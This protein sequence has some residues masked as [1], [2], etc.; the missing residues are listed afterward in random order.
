LKG[1]LEGVGGGGGGGGVSDEKN[2][3]DRGLGHRNRNYGRKADNRGL[4]TVEK[5]RRR[6][7]KTTVVPAWDPFLK[8]WG[9][10]RRKP[11][12][13]GSEEAHGG[14]RK[15][16]IDA[17]PK[18]ETGFSPHPLQEGERHQCWGKKF[19][20]MRGGWACEDREKTGEG[21]KL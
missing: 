17:L 15:Q 12:E 13:N 7:K 11:R 6:K 20:V 19:V 18:R 21:P 14:G 10:L 2:C 1:T 9:I 3:P 16:K 4:D 8:L 5:I